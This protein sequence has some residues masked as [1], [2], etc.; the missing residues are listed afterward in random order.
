MAKRIVDEEMRFTV[1]INGNEAQKEL[2]QL[3]KSTR[4]LTQT[5]KNL[6]AEKDKLRAQGKQDSQEYKNLTAKIKENN[7]ALT[8]NKNRMKVLQDQLGLTGLTMR[9]LS[10]RSSQLKL[11]LHNMVPGSAQYIKLQADLK[12]VDARMQELRMSSRAAQS[13]IGRL[14]DGFNRYFALGASVVAAGTGVVLS[15]QKMIDYNGK[16]SDA[17]A[18]VMKT[19]GMEKK[20]VDELTKSFGMFS[21]R[22]ARIELLKLAEDAGRLGITGVDNLR[23][24]VEVANQIKVALGDD[25]NENQIMEVGKMTQIYEVGTQTG[26]DFAEANLALG[27]SINEVSASGANQAGFLVD[28]LKR[29]AGIA[30]QAK[31]SADQN[32][33]YAATFDEIG[34]SVE[35]SATAMNKVW[36][37]MFDDTGTYA[38]I[39]GM[40]LKDFNNLLQTD[41]N[42]AMIKFLEGLN[43]NNEG[44]SVMVEKLKDI[45][46]GGARG[47]QA[48]SALAGSTDKLRERQKLANEALAEASSLTDEYNVKNNNLGA[49]LEKIQKKLIGMIASEAIVNRLESWVIWFAKFVG[50]A[51]DA[52]GEVTIWRERLLAAFKVLMVITAAMLSYQAAIRLV[53]MWTARSTTITKIHYALLLAQEI[54]T[55]SL[56]LAKALLTGNIQKAII[57]Y[58]GLTAAMS[59]NPIGAIVAVVGAAVAAYYAFSESAEKAATAQSIMNDASTEAIKTTRA[60]VNE[61]NGLIAV[62]KDEAISKEQRVKAIVRLNEISPEYLGNLNLENISTVEATK[63]LDDYV[64]SLVRAAKAK[65]IKAQLDA[66]AEELANAE[67]SSLEDNI[68]WYEKL[69]NQISNLNNTYAAAGDNVRTAINNKNELI[70]VTKA[71]LELLEEQYKAQL[72]VNAQED[73]KRNPGAPAGPKEG[74][75]QIIDGDLYVFTGGRWKKEVIKPKGD[76]DG[77]KKDEYKVDVN[78]EANELRRIQ[79]E[80]DRLKASLISESFKREI[81]LE[82]ANH[83]AKI[84]KLREQMIEEAELLAIDKEIV[85]ATNAGDTKKVDALAKTKE[86][87]IQRNA[88]LNR[89]VEFEESIHQNKIGSIIQ[90]GLEDDFQT[91]QKAYER[92]KRQREIAHNEQMAALGNDKKA[93]K[94]LQDKFNQEETDREA[95]HLQ[96]L[97]AKMKAIMD[98]G[99]FKGFELELLTEDQKQALLDF[100]AEANLKLSDL[101]NKASGG[102]GIDTKRIDGDVDILGFTIDQWDTTL[103]NLDTAAGKLEAAQM[104]IGA[105][106]NAWS[107]YNNFVAQKQ[108]VEL[109]QFERAQEAKQRTLERQL[110]AGYINQRQYNKSVEE[111]EKESQRKRAEME[112][113]AAKREK[114][115]AIT[116]IILNTAMGVAKAMAQG[117]FVLGV[118]WAAVVGALGAIQLGLALA[119]PLPAKGFEDGLYPVKREQ[120]GQMFKAGYGG[121]TKSG[122]VK[123][124]TLFLAGE[125]NKPEMIIDNRAWKKMDPDVKNSLY[126]ELSRVKGFES[127]YYPPQPQAAA[128]RGSSSSS[129]EEDGTLVLVLN[130]AV[131]VLDR[132][133]KNGVIA[134]LSRNLENAKMIQDD[135]DDYNK[136]RNANKR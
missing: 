66:K 109:Q 10:Q 4:E 132:L 107:M 121:D 93:R 54:A 80:N 43:G 85:K 56:A 18:D 40:S 83:Q 26:K 20:A 25:L 112:Y 58:R 51:E 35:I 128:E 11:Q 12:A 116:G 103:N 39:A 13:S 119:T 100:L 111:L 53:A 9:Q 24:Y 108:Q 126:R 6:K 120:D 133:E 57:A 130:R 17:Q 22:T 135:I 2:F 16:L 98:G 37:D 42:E 90:K 114:E 131:N 89:Q 72:K 127:G 81:A 117:G 29:Q 74:E 49:T 97:I 92:E 77:K 68:K 96:D 45:D 134:R 19:T 8:D 44:L 110:N 88:A 129:V 14:A 82:E 27:S 63:S 105:M 123:K 48:L 122:L 67:G 59:L 31:I 32:I 36:M 84:A 87:W 23:N 78:K 30:K 113:K 94:A 33:G 34:Q 5:N 106:M 115:M 70:D 79:E 91:S 47:A 65:A 69:W 7:L 104:A 1:V 28:Y 136:L 75:K 46:V 15:I 71:E 118:P 52:S 95:K 50:A 60:E 61:I 76:P 3:E 101:L 102:S 99:D 62:A 64:D 55:K 125:K 38:K 124:P 73:G 86:L 41:S 21:T